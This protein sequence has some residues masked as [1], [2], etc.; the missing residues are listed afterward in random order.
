MYVTALFSSFYK[1][2]KMSSLI[3]TTNNIHEQRKP[4]QKNEWASHYL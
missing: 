2:M 3:P 1:P 4:E